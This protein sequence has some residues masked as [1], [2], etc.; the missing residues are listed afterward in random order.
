MVFPIRQYTDGAE[1]L[2]DLGHRESFFVVQFATDKQLCVGK[3]LPDNN[4]HTITQNGVALS[5]SDNSLEFDASEHDEREE[6]YLTEHLAVCRNAVRSCPAGSQPL[7]PRAARRGGE[8]AQRTHLIKSRVRWQ[9][10]V[11]SVWHYWRETES[12][13]SRESPV[14]NNEG[15]QKSATNSKFTLSFTFSYCTPS[16]TSPFL[17]RKL[18]SLRACFTTNS[19]HITHWRTLPIQ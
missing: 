18:P 12:M 2:C 11:E 13:C 19:T 9:L 3:I 8:Q 17:H 1:G 15:T 10:K 6:V 5:S 14:S 4:T 16:C 7:Y